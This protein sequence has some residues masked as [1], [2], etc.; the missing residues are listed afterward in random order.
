M[1][2]YTVIPYY[3]DCEGMELFLNDVRSFTT[4]E[5]AEEYAYTFSNNDYDIVES[6]LD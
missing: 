1:K 6:E 2:I 4:F 5:K 3:S